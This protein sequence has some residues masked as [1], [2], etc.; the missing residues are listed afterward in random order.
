MRENE[1]IICRCEDLTLE[2]IR[3]A[4]ADGYTDFEELK[5]YLRCGMGP[6]G[7]RTCLPLIRRELARVKGVPVEDVAM[8]TSRPPVQVTTFEAISV[9]SERGK[10]E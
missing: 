9:G 10:N 6:C 8:P 1:T 2:D 4:I 7:G 5:R 3:S